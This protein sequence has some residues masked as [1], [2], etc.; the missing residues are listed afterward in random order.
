[1]NKKLLA[2]A[3]IAAMS[4]SSISAAEVSLLDANS[5]HGNASNL[6]GWGAQV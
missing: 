1:M 4:V 3:A 2:L 5:I 6:S